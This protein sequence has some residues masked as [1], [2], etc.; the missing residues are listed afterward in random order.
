MRK[1]SITKLSVSVA[2]MLLLIGC[3]CLMPVVHW[4]NATGEKTIDLYLIGGQSNAAGYSSKGTLPSETFSNVYYAGQINKRRADGITAQNWL[5]DYKQQVAA[6]YGR[7]AN[8]IGPEYGIA[9][10]ING[11][12]SQSAPAMIFKSAAGGTALRNESGGESADFGNWYPR[13]LWNGKQPNAASSPMGVQY[14]NFV[15]NF[16]TVYDKLTEDGYTVRVKGMAWMQ[17][18][19]DVEHPSAYESLLKTFIRDIRTDLKQIT[20][21]QSLDSMPFVIGEIA[22]TFS[23]YNNVYVPPFIAAQRKVALETA[24]VYSV[25]TDDLIINNSDGS[26]NGTDYWHFN[27][28]DAVTLGERFGK[29]LAVAAGK[30]DS[31]TRLGSFVGGDLPQTQNGTLTY[32]VNDNQRT[33]TITATPESGY[34]ITAFTVDGKDVRSELKNNEYTTTWRKDL[35]VTAEFA[36]APKPLY[37]F[38]LNFDRTKGKAFLSGYSVTEGNS[39]SVTV[40]PDDGYEVESVTLNGTAL[41]YDETNKCYVFDSVNKSGTVEVKFKNLSNDNDGGC[42][43]VAAS[44]APVFA[45]IMFALAAMVFFTKRG[46]KA[47]KR[48]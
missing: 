5:T 14:L 42:G 39:L 1:L 46:K 10:V 22:T 18:C 29:A 41:R 13:S 8:C 15:E 20:G 35:D 31:E 48:I 23:A 37:T 26:I 9:K 16:K 17:G 19:A 27:V 45:M 38:T 4:A 21:E 3:V 24:N 12:Y 32:T 11:K 7:D 33:V 47:N 43:S 2:V 30:A 44:S 34:A 40:T 28:A 25:R 6:G 36:P